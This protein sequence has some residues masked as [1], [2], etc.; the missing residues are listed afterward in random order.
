MEQ[1][2]H[3]VPIYL[4]PHILLTLTNVSHEGGAFVIPNEPILICYYLLKFILF[5]DFLSFYLMF[6]F[7]SRIPSWTPYSIGS[8]EDH[9]SDISILKNVLQLEFL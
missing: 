5:A 4:H 7:C 6:L 1:I 8:F 2:A 3:R 9:W